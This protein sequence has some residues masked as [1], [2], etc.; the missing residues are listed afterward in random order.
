[1]RYISSSALSTALGLTESV[2]VWWPAEL[3]PRAMSGR[4]RYEDVNAWL[5]APGRAHGFASPP[6]IEQ[7]LSGQIHLILRERAVQML[8]SVIRWQDPASYVWQRINKGRLEAL[9]LRNQTWV[10]TRESVDRLIEELQEISEHFTA[11]QTQWIF[12]VGQ[13]SRRNAVSFSTTFRTLAKRGK[14]KLILNP[15]DKNNLLLTRASAQRLLEELLL[16]AGSRLT[17]ED[18]I[19]DREASSAPL[20]T[21]QDAAEYL[22]LTREEMRALLTAGDVQYIPSPERSKWLVSP[23]SLELYRDGMPPLT[24]EQIGSIFGA[25]IRAVRRWRSEG[26]LTCAIHT[27]QE[28]PCPLYRWCLVA[29]VKRSARAG[30]QA[31]QWVSSALSKQ[32][33]NLLTEKSALEV[34]TPKRLNVGVETGRIP[35]VLTPGGRRVYMAFAVHGEVKRYK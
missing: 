26:L 25:Q 31:D 29:C 18:W 20:M 7:I 33:I 16:A 5:A 35:S 15:D 11:S 34:L 4:H 14:V 17:A 8:A 27:D 13:A 12:G 6:T 22:G 23:D 9:R 28:T 3:K 2:L 30:V 32:G 19:D 21:V 24:A 10:V 1:M